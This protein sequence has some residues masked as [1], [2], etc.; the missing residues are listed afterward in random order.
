MPAAAIGAARVTALHHARRVLELA[1][2]FLLQLPQFLHGVAASLPVTLAL[3]GPTTACLGRTL[4]A[5]LSTLCGRGLPRRA[6]LAARLAL[7]A[8]FAARAT[9]VALGLL[10]QRGDAILE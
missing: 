7:L 1:R 2:V 10:R 3:A 8:A 6:V 4:V 5:G 9:S